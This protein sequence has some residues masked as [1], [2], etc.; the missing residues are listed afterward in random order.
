MQKITFCVGG[1]GPDLVV[2]HLINKPKHGMKKKNAMEA[3]AE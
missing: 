3:T 2:K 1:E